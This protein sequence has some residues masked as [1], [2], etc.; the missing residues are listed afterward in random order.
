M[1]DAGDI[2][3]LLDAVGTEWKVASTLGLPSRVATVVPTNNLPV[4]NFSLRYL[5][6]KFP[7]GIYSHQAQAARLFDEGK[8]VLLATSTAS[9]K[10]ACFYVA[11][12]ETLQKDPRAK[13]V[14][15][16]PLKALGLEQEARWQEAIRLS[17]LSVSV[18]RID[19]SVPVRERPRLFERSSIV[20]MTPDVIHAWLLN[21]L[22]NEQIAREVGRIRLVIADE[23]H[24]Y[25]GVFGSNAAYLFRRLNHASQLLGGTALRFMSASATIAKASEHARALFGDEFAVVSNEE[26]GSPRQ[27]V[28]I[29]LLTPAVDAPDLLTSV[30]ALLRRLVDLTEHKFICFN[31]SRKQVETIAT[32]IGRRDADTSDIPDSSRDSDDLLVESASVLPFR[33]GYEESNRQAIQRRL[34]S[35][36]L[37]GVVS[38]SA[39]ELGMDIPGLDLAVLVGIPQSSTSLWQRIGRIGRKAPGTVLIL[40][41]GSPED[42]MLFESPE[43]VLDRPLADS[44]MYLDNVFVRYIHA[45]CLGR[46][47]GEHDAVATYLR[48]TDADAFRSPVRWP[49]GF[50]D[51]VT[52]EQSGSIPAQLQALKTQ[53]GENPNHAFP[54]RDVSPSYTVQLR[55]GPNRRDIGSL[56]HAQVMREAYP[57]AVYLHLTAPYRVTSVNDSSRIVQVR[58][59]KFYPTKPI[60]LPTQAF[61]NFAPDSV[62]DAAQWG[63]LL[64]FECELQI[65]ERVIGLEERRGSNRFQTTYPMSAA[66]TGIYFDRSVFRRSIFTTGV[67]LAHRALCLADKDL[68]LLAELLLRSLELLIPFDPSDISITKDKLRVDQPQ[69]ERGAPI[70]VFYDQTY[71][72]LRLTSRLMEGNLLAETIHG[73]FRMTEYL[74]PNA[75]EESTEARVQAVRGALA[76]MYEDALSDRSSPTST[77]IEETASSGSVKV[78]A[79]GSKGVALKQNNLEFEVVAVYFNP[80]VGGLCYR[81]RLESDSASATHSSIL[82]IEEVVPIPGVS[83]MAHYSLE[84]GELTEVSA[85]TSEDEVNTGVS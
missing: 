9:G 14:V 50:E 34:E 2:T 29:K 79:P 70:V 7:G 17:G 22:R 5:N 68:E 69:M 53:G 46:P 61:P 24:V 48:M 82:R 41:S 78:I 1:S 25:S 51:L 59:E 16:Y 18:G 42:N 11:A 65:S 67:V 55:D 10:S 60:A 57:G 28:S 13:V 27:P 84:T 71:G 75:S 35:G 80:Q 19:G 31:D 4:S 64:A 8:N 21:N 3:K 77:Y 15:T 44:R 74:N 23:L 47:E 43:R 45:M 66:K 32:I 62:L 6:R 83:R 52:N 58:R 56:S 81:G 20:V 73:A 38:T 26:D 37:R 76:E 33:S 36:D 12:I 85:G 72:S 39:L 40:N 49:E 63:D 30:S 54:L